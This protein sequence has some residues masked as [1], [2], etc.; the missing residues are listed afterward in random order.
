VPFAWS[1]QATSVIDGLGSTLPCEL[2]E[3]CVAQG[4]V[5]LL[6]LGDGDEKTEGCGLK[7]RDPRDWLLDARCLSCGAS[8][9]P[10]SGPSRSDEV[11]RP[12]VA[13][14]RGPPHGFQ[15]TNRITP[16]RLPA[17][18]CT[19]PDLRPGALSC[20]V[21]RVSSIAATDQDSCTLSKGLKTG[22][23]VQ[24]AEWRFRLE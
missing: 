2:C 20:A 22:T 19:V 1:V 4:T 6:I 13:L 9:G 17:S 5:W 23:K 15:S 3:V 8:G 7:R 16:W 14:Q 11:E 18:A 12:V 21:L 10:A 24:V